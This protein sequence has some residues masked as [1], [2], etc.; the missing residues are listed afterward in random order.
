MNQQSFMKIGSAALEILADKVGVTHRDK[1]QPFDES[2]L[3]SQRLR[4]NKKI[5]KNYK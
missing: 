4:A 3:Y 2:S 1:K 5:I